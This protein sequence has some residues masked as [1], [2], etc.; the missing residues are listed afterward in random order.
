MNNNQKK[1]LRSL[2]HHKKVTIWIGQKGLTDTVFN[3]IEQAL[4]HHEL[5]K[6]KIR[7]G[8]REERDNIVVKICERTSAFLLQTRGSIA[9]IYRANPEKPV[10]TLP[11]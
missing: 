11:N 5:I 8:D 1:F 2:L 9:S 7:N 4:N 10:L 6:I 3:E